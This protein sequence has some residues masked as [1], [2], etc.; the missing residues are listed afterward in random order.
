MARAVQ[1]AMVA[2]MCSA[3]LLHPVAAY[4]FNFGGGGLLQ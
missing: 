4:N 1:I 2:V 3:L